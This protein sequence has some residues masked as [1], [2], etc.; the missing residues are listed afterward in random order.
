MNFLT[1]CRVCGRFK[2]TATCPARAAVV[3]NV[4][5]PPHD[6]QDAQGAMHGRRQGQ[7]EQRQADHD[8]DFEHLPRRIAQIA[9]QE[10]NILEEG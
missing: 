7:R 3:L 9:I 1:F 6:V 2:H 5:V 4:A 8:N 10:Q